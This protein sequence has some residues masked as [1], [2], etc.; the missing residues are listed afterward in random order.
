MCLDKRGD[1]EEFADEVQYTR[2]YVVEHINDNLRDLRVGKMSWFFC[3][4][5]Y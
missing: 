3:R 5:I 1:W 2:R 4:Y